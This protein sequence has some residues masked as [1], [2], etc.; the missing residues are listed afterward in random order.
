MKSDRE[1]IFFSVHQSK[2]NFIYMKLLGSYYTEENVR[3]RLEKK[4]YKT[5]APKHLSKE[6]RLYINISTY[7]TTGNWERFERWAKLNNLLNYEDFQ[8]YIS[9]MENSVKADD[10]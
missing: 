5:K 9:D 8:Q 7:V 3:T 4:R 10:Q 6:T 2:K 1:N